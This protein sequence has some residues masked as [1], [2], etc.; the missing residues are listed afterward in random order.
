MS[1][2]YLNLER[3][4]KEIWHAILFAAASVFFHFVA[5]RDKTSKCR[6]WRT[7]MFPKSRC[8]S[9]RDDLADIV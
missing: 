9:C 8:L 7:L 2:Q 1:L 6:T 4:V 3:E 5:T